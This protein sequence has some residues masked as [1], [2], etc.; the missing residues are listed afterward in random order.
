[1]ALFARVVGWALWWR[2]F[3]RPTVGGVGT[4]GRVQWDQAGENTRS[5][6]RRAAP[7]TPA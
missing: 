5:V 1:M 2:W 4:V 6:I 7:M 3:R